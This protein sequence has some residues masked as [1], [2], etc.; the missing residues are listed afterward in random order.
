[1]DHTHFHTSYE[2]QA[3]LSVP[4][5]DMTCRFSLSTRD[6]IGE[7]PLFD[8]PYESAHIECRSS[9]IQDAGEGLYAK[10]DIPEGQLKFQT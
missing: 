2:L 5:D 3:D 1:M 8:D 7:E 6:W 9:A 4:R 10:H